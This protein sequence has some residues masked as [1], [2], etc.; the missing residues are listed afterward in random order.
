ME[1][2]MLSSNLIY[3]RQ[4]H[5]SGQPI[6]YVYAYLRSKDSNTAKAGTPYYIGKGKETRAFE[7][8][9][10]IPIP[11]KHSNVLMIETNLTELGAYAIER[12]LIRRLGRKDLNTG[13][14]LNK[15]DGGEAM[16]GMVLTKETKQK[17]GVGI[18]LSWKD[19]NSKFNSSQ[20]RN[21][22]AKNIIKMR[23]CRNNQTNSKI[24]KTVTELWRDP[25]SIY[26]N[27]EFRKSRAKAQ[28]KSYCVITPNG[29]SFIVKCLDHFCRENDLSTSS[30]YKVAR[31]VTKS[32]KKWKCIKV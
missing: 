25:N 17:R 18:S 3:T 28:G 23:N 13:I 26:N 31:G 5:N 19:P 6:Y 16:H 29:K 2:T 11:T 15:T 21:Y 4:K 12:Q 30:M 10:K 20:F 14:L 27:G 24:A 9:N 1:I 32:H 22:M 8:H 7:P